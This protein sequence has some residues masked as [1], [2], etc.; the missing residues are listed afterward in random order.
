MNIQVDLGRRGD[1]SGA[2]GHFSDLF[3]GLTGAGQSQQRRH[4]ANA[5]VWSRA[6]RDVQLFTPVL[7]APPP[8]PLQ[9]LS[10]LFKNV[11]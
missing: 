5:N 2:S 7:Q 9:H 11:N 3:S 8:T 6:V 10:L 1:G 4:N